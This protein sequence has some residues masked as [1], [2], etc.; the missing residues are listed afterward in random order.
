MI[1]TNETAAYEFPF[2]LEMIVASVLRVYLSCLLRCLDRRPVQVASGCVYQKTVVKKKYTG[3]L[4]H[5]SYLHGMYLTLDSLC[6][7]M[8]LGLGCR[9]RWLRVWRWLV[10]SGLPPCRSH[11][12]RYFANGSARLWRRSVEYANRFG[13][14]VLWFVEVYLDVGC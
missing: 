10:V 14:W 5:V 7:L 4:S 9:C 8:S 13:G 6:P 3:Y 12:V 2:Y 11:V 1:T